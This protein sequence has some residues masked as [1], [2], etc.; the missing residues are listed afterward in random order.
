MFNRSNI[1]KLILITVVWLIA[2]C[3]VTLHEYLFLT[4][5]PG[6]LQTSPMVG[7]EFFKNLSAAAI[8][9]GCGGFLLGILELFVFQRMVNR[10]KFW[11]AVMYKMAIYSLALLAIIT[12]T[13]WLF[14][15]VLSG[16]T[17]WASE[18][19]HQT[20]HFITSLSFWHPVTPFLVLALIT[21]FFIQLTERFS[22]QELFR[23]ISGKYFNPKEE[24]R[25]FMFLDLNGS[26]TLAE[27]LGNARF[28]ELLNDFFFDMAQSIE[29]NLGEVV[30]YVGDEIVICWKMDDGLNQSRCL[31]CFFDIEEVIRQRSPVYRNK[32]GVVPAF[33]AA[34]HCG[35]V[36]IGEIGK[37]KKSIKYSGDVLNTTARVEQ[38][39]NKIKAKLAATGPLIMQLESMPYSTERVG[40]LEL[41]GKTET[42]SVYRIS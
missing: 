6:V 22:M 11:K 29:S 8:A 30:E 16:R 21:L 9:L 39:C 5:Y 1:Y 27:Q 33:K 18:G 10:M 25:I 31:K 4:N 2:G 19:L 42:V 34:V 3:L 26:T 36:I 15:T 20:Y 40:D 35:D 24:A 13:S 17:L 7:Y 41:R 28:Y 38:M 32:Y 37:I 14:N 12:G 23:L